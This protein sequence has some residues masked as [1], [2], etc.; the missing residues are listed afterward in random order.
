MVIFLNK[1]HFLL[2]NILIFFY[3]FPPALC[4]N[5]CQLEGSPRGLIVK[6]AED[7][8][9]KRELTRLHNLSM[10]NPHRDSNP[11]NV[12]NEP[13]SPQY[14]YPSSNVP[15]PSMYPS[16]NPISIVHSG[17]NGGQ[18][19]IPPNSANPNSNVDPNGN[20]KFQKSRKFPNEASPVNVPLPVQSS[21]PAPNWYPNPQYANPPNP[22]QFSYIVQNSM[23]P[24]PPYDNN[25]YGVFPDQAQRMHQVSYFE[26]VPGRTNFPESA[27]NNRQKFDINSNQQINRNLP[28][29]MPNSNYVTLS[30][31]NL[32]PTA[33]SKLLNE[34]F[35]PYGVVVNTSIESIKHNNHS[36][37]LRGKVE[38]LNFA[39]A[40][41]A[42]KELNGFTL[43]NDSLPLQVCF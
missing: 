5:G 24:T 36:S 27:P 9:K 19:F 15:I 16:A 30:V 28:Q 33:D 42:A 21:P 8:H 39:Q 32:P 7:Q 37:Y 4:L 40:E 13:M 2:K 35:A 17:M 23:R 34:L 18:Y 11:Q 38:M 3:F 43:T 6:Y 20:K 25:A 22:T 1:L 31:L 12:V 14:Y 26:N 10:N 29:K 41:H